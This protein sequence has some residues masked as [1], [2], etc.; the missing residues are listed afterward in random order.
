MWQ[1]NLRKHAAIF[2]ID[3]SLVQLL[4]VSYKIIYLRLYISLQ[5]IK[6]LW[7][8]QIPTENFRNAYQGL[9]IVCLEY[10]NCKYFPRSVQ[11]QIIFSGE[12]IEDKN[13]VR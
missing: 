6:Y 7:V 8:H 2:N 9:S 10:I 4:I 1:T 5:R 12:K 3:V 13:K 11:K